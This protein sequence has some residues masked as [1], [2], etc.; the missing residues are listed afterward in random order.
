MLP[1]NHKPSI[2][3]TTAAPTLAR[4]RAPAPILT[5]KLLEVSLELLAGAEE[6]PSLFSAH[7][8]GALLVHGDAGHLGVQLGESRALREAPGQHSTAWGTIPASHPS[9][10]FFFPFLSNQCSGLCQNFV[11]L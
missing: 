2:G 6:D 3:G 10:V 9:G 5:A 4:E 11:A 7:H 1:P 8:E